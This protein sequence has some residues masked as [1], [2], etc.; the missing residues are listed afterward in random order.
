MKHM[1]RQEFIAHLRR[2]SRL[3]AF[4]PFS[5]LY[6]SEVYMAEKH[7]NYQTLLA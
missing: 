4:L 2:Y 7:G 1:T 5:R 6:H 3:A